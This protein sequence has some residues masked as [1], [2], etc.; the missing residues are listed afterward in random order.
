MNNLI[1]T[2]RTKR[3]LKV[4]AN[5]DNIT[6]AME[7][8]RDIIKNERYG[9][10]NDIV[11]NFIK[12]NGRI[13]YGGMAIDAALKRKGDRIYC[14]DEFPDFDFYSP[15]Y[16]RDSIILTNKLYKAG[17]KY[18]RRIPAKHTHTVRIQID[19]NI[20]I[21]D[22]GYLDQAHFDAIDTFTY[23][24]VK[25]ISPDFMKITFFKSL[26]MVKN[27]Y[28]WKKDIQRINKIQDYYPTPSGK[29]HSDESFPNLNKEI[30]S[31][32]YD[33]IIA[34]N[35]DKNNTVIL[36]NMLYNLYN[37]FITK[38]FDL[39]HDQIKDELKQVS[40]ILE[41]HANTIQIYEY[42][43]KLM[44]HINTYLKKNRLK[45]KYYIVLNVYNGDIGNFLE[46]KYVIKVIEKSQGSFVSSDDDQ[47]LLQEYPIC[48][49]YNGF[50]TMT[51]F[52]HIEK[53][54]INV[55]NYNH[56]VHTLYTYRYYLKIQGLKTKFIT[57]IDVLKQ[58][59]Y[60]INNIDYMIN[61][62]N[63]M[64]KEFWDKYNLQG[65]EEKT[66]TGDTNIFQILQKDSMGFYL[67]KNII[68]S[69][70][71]NTSCTSV[72][73]LI[74]HPVYVP[75]IEYIN[76]KD[77]SIKFNPINVKIC[78][79]SDTPT[80]IEGGQPKIYGSISTSKPTSVE[81]VSDLVDVEK[82]QYGSFYLINNI[83][84]PD[85]NTQKTTDEKKIIVLYPSDIDV[86]AYRRIVI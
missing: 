12:E 68:P 17:Y 36:G 79:V 51:Q 46:Q 24:G 1:T 76:I 82:K 18:V 16:I 6:G 57:F 67:E 64:N 52:K 86:L 75:D 59:Y 34:N 8:H 14:G 25:Y 49:I 62:I 10:A 22:I 55:L 26:A 19:F 42:I 54:G 9:K 85:P 15:D 43:D 7:K 70:Y 66:K 31:Y 23:E 84:I 71:L 73:N 3:Q 21:A 11:Y 39:S 81:R 44:V 45:D 28:R 83:I 32:L 47:I 56:F 53:L 65:Y 41:L 2:V 61:Q 60:N 4:L 37:I 58:L 80:K 29:K 78:L 77:I 5:M 63:I 20:Y 13:L 40:P 69:I 74:N 48:V 38:G 72:F 27:L 50:G 30:F 33:Q 35:F